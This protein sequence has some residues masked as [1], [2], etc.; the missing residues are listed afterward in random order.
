MIKTRIE[1]LHLSGEMGELP[2]T[3][4]NLVLVEIN[5]HRHVQNMKTLSSMRD[6]YGPSN[7][8]KENYQILVQHIYEYKGF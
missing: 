7:V 5:R 2:V 4:L 3:D 1:R 6:M 8:R